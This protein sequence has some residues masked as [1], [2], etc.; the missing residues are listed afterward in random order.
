MVLGKAVKIEWRS[1]WQD[2]APM[3]PWEWRKKNRVVAG[4]ITAREPF[5]NQGKTARQTSG[6][7]S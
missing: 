2:P 4:L 1:L 3:P 5:A 7:N 6:R